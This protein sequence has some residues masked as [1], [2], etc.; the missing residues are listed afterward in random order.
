MAKMTP[1]QQNELNELHQ[2]AKSL[3]E[4]IGML[5]AELQ[6]S[7]PYMPTPEEWAA[8][9]EAIAAATDD[10]GAMCLY[11]KKPEIGVVVWW[12]ANGGA[13][14]LLRYITPPAHFRTTLRHR[15]EGI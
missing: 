6:D 11:E 7:D 10:S 9:P 12:N 14:D 15:P 3:L 5:R 4:R 13:Y 2:L 8:H 1:E